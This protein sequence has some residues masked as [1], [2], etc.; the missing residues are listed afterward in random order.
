MINDPQPISALIPKDKIAFDIDGVVADIMTTFINLGRERYGLEHLR[1]EDITDFYL[2]RCL[3]MEEAIIMEILEMLI[4]RPHELEIKPLPHAVQVL[5]QLAQETPLLFITARD[6]VEPIQTWLHQ[7]LTKVPPQAI[8]IIATGDPDIKLEYLHDHGIDYFVE[9]RL[10]TCWQL[11][12][13]GVTPIVYDQ[14]WN[15]RTHPFQIV[16]N[17]Q[18]IARLL[19]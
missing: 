9:D 17:W 16:Y 3:R 7:T 13:N 6:K 18:D 2:H 12:Q 5:T 19:F 8:R 4:D 15:R 14:P 11:S 10:D 1:Y